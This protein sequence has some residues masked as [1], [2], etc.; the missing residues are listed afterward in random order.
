MHDGNAPQVDGP[1]PRGRLARWARA[2]VLPVA[3]IAAIAVAMYVDHSRRKPLREAL[4]SVDFAQRAHFER[5]R[6][7][8]TAV[9][10]AQDRRTIA[11][12]APEGV[13]VRILV[14]GGDGWSAIATLA[15]MNCGIYSGPAR[16]SPNPA[17]KV[18]GRPACW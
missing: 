15:G 3:V 14:A 18:A 9:G 4:R 10:A 11:L 5:Y 1:R 13:A 7:Y 16:F 12:A 2:P 8:A 6:V 17:V